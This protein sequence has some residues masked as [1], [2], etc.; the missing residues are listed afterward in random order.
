MLITSHKL[1]GSGLLLLTLVARCVGM[2]GVQPCYKAHLAG[3]TPQHT[4]TTHANVVSLLSAL[5][6]KLGGHVRLIQR[7]AKETL[8]GEFETLW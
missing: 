2:R 7:S 6:T 1:E 4:L 3:Q 5:S 8:A